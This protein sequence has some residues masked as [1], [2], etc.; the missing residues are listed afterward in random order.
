MKKR[1]LYNKLIKNR[2]ENEK[3]C[4]KSVVE[5]KS[6]EL[7]KAINEEEKLMSVCYDKLA[8]EDELSGEERNN[9][10]SVLEAEAESLKNTSLNLKKSYKLVAAMADELETRIHE[11]EKSRK[12]RILISAPPSNTVIDFKEEKLNNF[13]QGLNFYKLFLICFTG[14][15]AGVIVEIIWCLIRNGYIESRSGLVYGPFNLLYGFGAVAM[16][17]ALYKYRNRSS[18]ISFAGGMIM[19]SVVE[20]LCSWGQE[21]VLGSRSW[22]YSDMPFNLN[23]RICLLYSVFW[24]I[25][26]VMWIKNVY[27]RMAKVILHIPNKTGKI[28]TWIL[29]AF[30]AVNVVVSGFAVLR[31]SERVKGVEATGVFEELIDERFPDERMERIYPNMKF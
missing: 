26:G 5:Q 1:N 12:R 31:W 29:A 17:M 16:T 19:G 24:G 6:T 7:I 28:M 27:P 4:K 18:S 23:G 21:M 14:S 9:L 25:L 8:D 3:N 10:N 20:Y 22:D 11:V 15:F 2:I 13:A 30:M